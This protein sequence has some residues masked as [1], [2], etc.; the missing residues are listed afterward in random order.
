MAKKPTFTC[1]RCGQTE[2]K[3]P[4]IFVPFLMDATKQEISADKLSARMRNLGMMK[5]C[6]SCAEKILIFMEK[7]I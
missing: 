2:N 1:D 5:M 4:H 7:P 6:T 3:N